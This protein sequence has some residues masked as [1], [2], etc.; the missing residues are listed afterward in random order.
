MSN[1]WESSAWM[2]N[3]IRL[4]S[5]IEFTVED[6]EWKSMFPRI[7][8]IVELLNELAHLNWIG[9]NPDYFSKCVRILER[10]TGQLAAGKVRTIVKSLFWS[11]FNWQRRDW[12][13][14]GTEPRQQ[15]RLLDWPP[16][17][18][19]QNTLGGRS[20]DIVSNGD[21]YEFGLSE[22]IACSLITC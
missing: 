9:M 22:F 19:V 14:R 5:W 12:A 10:T 18:L 21:F 1:C 13:G 15:E 6:A 2:D 20:E 17:S 7:S 11:I 4:N 3:L 8:W 16:E